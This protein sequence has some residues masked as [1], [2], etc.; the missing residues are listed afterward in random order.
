MPRQSCRWGRILR[1]VLATLRD[2]GGLIGGPWPGIAVPATPVVLRAR[3]LFPIAPRRPLKIHLYILRQLL[4][5]FLFA[6][7]ALLFIALPGI[8]VNT[9][10][11]LPNVDA[12][13]LLQFL[14]LVLQ[15]LAPYVLPLC[16]MLAT[17][18]VFGRLAADKE[19]IAIHMAGIHPLKTLFMP[20]L[21]AT[22]LGLLTFWMVSNELPQLKKRQKRFLVNAAASVIDNLQPGKTSLQIGD[23]MLLASARD[24]ESGVFSDVYLRVPE[25]DED[26]Q[27]DVFAQHAAVV[28]DGDFLIISATN[29]E[30]FD[31]EDGVNSQHQHVIVRVNLAERF[32]EAPE[33]YDRG[34]YLVSSEVRERLT[35]GG[36][37]PKREREYRFMLHYR[38]SMFAIFF[39]FLGLGAATGLLMRRGTQL[40]ALAVAAGYG[41]V[42]YVLSMRLGKELGLS[43]S[44]PPWV[45]AWLTTV[46][47][48]GI[49]VALLR[50]ALRR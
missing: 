38:A 4:V 24:L 10:H 28:V 42:Y 43:S 47:G 32:D 1:P 26:P 48:G 25:D 6:V 34:K 7:G 50:R 2:S 40:G 5:A 13:I 11:K 27:I 20:F 46:V 21:V 33:R 49:A 29:V 12:S 39:L 35:E 17:V 45:G 31:S 14:P 36:L 23:F 30:T 44:L 41:I 15:S 19:W 22:A 8:A 37:E 16:F 3:R 18:A 9:V